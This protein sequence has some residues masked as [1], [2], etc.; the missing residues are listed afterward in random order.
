M[1]GSS[2]RTSVRDLPR[3]VTLLLRH[4]WE[5]RAHGRRHACMRRGPRARSRIRRAADGWPAS[6]ITAPRP[7]AMAS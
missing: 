6:F 3:V 2:G 1:G 5:G 4:W 7:A